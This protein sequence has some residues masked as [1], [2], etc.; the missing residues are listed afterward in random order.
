MWWKVQLI[1]R[2]VWTKNNETIQEVVQ[3]IAPWMGY[4]NSLYLTSL[5]TITPTNIPTDQIIWPIKK[6]TFIISEHEW[7]INII[8]KAGT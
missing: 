4:V 1:W 3:K 6:V 8:N 7:I 5:T 2:S